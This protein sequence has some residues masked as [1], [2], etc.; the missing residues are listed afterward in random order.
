ML[1]RLG[2]LYAC[3]AGAGAAATGAAGLD[4]RGLHHRR[5]GPVPGLGPART[6]GL[7]ALHAATTCGSTFGNGTRAFR[8]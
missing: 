8:G 2:P 5:R 1:G 7:L 4:R 6:P 3:G